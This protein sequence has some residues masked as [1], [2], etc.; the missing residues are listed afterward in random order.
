MC[1]CTKVFT[2]RHFRD[3]VN[4]QVRI[5]DGGNKFLSFINPPL[6]PFNDPMIP[7][8]ALESIIPTS[9][10]GILVNV[11]QHCVAYYPLKEH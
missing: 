6:T 3:I 4:V 9:L 10:F 5:Q 2:T 11:V 1:K 7:F 8:H